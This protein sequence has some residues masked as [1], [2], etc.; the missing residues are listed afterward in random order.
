[1]GNKPWDS[2]LGLSDVRILRADMRRKG[3]VALEVVVA[4]MNEGVLCEKSME[5]LHRLEQLLR[6]SPTLAVPDSALEESI[7]G[8]EVLLISVNEQER[9]VV[10]RVARD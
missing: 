9:D 10:E 1:M 2:C 6:V 5:T 3:E 8:E 4:R 7:S